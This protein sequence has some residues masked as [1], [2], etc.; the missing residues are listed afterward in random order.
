MVIV[1]GAPEIAVVMSE[2][3]LCAVAAALYVDL[4][5]RCMGPAS[6]KGTSILFVVPPA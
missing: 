1:V 3:C 5:L 2:A 4:L 6:W